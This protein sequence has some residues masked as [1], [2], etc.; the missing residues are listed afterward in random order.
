[1][2]TEHTPPRKL[3]IRP[4]FTLSGEGTSVVD[5]HN[6]AEL[7]AAIHKALALSPIARI[8]VLDYCEGP[9]SPVWEVF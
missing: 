3:L 8:D 1:M 6:E 4:H 5:E 9:V 2:P 7:H